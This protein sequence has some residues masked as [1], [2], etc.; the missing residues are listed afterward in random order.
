VEL[1]V[2]ALPA[3]FLPARRI[4]FNLRTAL[5][6]A[7]SNAIAYGNRYDVSKVVR[8]R[9]EVLREAIHIHVVDEGEGYRPDAVPDPTLPENRE[10][11][12]GRGLFVL[13]HIVDRVSFNEKGNAV[14]L[15]LLA[16]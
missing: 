10:R 5:A 13:R 12:G 11:E 15:T 3:D 8:V 7:L 2:N 6:E 9:A 4:R 14:C 16:G 1:L